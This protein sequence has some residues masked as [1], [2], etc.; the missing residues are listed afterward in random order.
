VNIFTAVDAAN[1]S[2]T[3]PSSAQVLLGWNTA[4]D[5]SGTAYAAGQATSIATNLT[6]YAQWSTRTI[7]LSETT[8]SGSGTELTITT[9]NG[10]TGMLPWSKQGSN[11][12]STGGGGVSTDNGVDFYT[13]TFNP[14]ANGRTYNIIQSGWRNDGAPEPKNHTAIF[15]RIV[16]SRNVNVTLNFDDIYMDGYV[17][18]ED[19][20]ELTLLL[21][22]TGSIGPVPAEK[23]WILQGI[24]GGAGSN[25]VVDSAAGTGLISG[26]IEIRGLNST[27]TAIDSAGRVAIIG[28]NT[29]LRGYDDPG[30]GVSAAVFDMSGGKLW[31]QG[32]TAGAG[33]G[34]FTFTGGTFDGKCIGAT[35]AGI[36]ADLLDVSAGTVRGVVEG[37]YG[38]YANDT[39]IS[40]GQVTAQVLYFSVPTAAGLGGTNIAIRGGDVTA[41]I[42]GEGSAISAEVLNISA[43]TV[44]ATAMSNHPADGGAGIGGGVGLAGGSVVISGGIVAAQGASGAAG[45]G[46]GAGGAGGSVTVTGGQVTA[47]G[48]DG[49]GA[50]IGGGAGGAGAV[51]AIDAAVDVLAYSWGDLPAIHSVNDNSD[52]GDG[53]YVN[54]VLTAAIPVATQ[55]DVTDPVNST[56]YR[57]L[58]LPRYYRA[59]AYSTGGSSQRNDEVWVCD[60]GGNLLG[61]IVRTAD[62]GVVYSMIDLG[63]YNPFNTVKNKGWLPVKFRHYFVVTE[64]HV[65]AAGIPLPA[66]VV[67]TVTQVPRATPVYSKG[68]PAL[69][70]YTPL[71]FY[72]GEVYPPATGSLDTGGTVRV[73][74]VIDHFTVYFVYAPGTDLTVTKIVTGANADK[75]RSFLFA[76]YFFDDAAGTDPLAATSF[77]FTKT[78]PGLDPPVE[79]ELEVEASNRVVFSLK[80]GESITIHGVPLA[81]YVQVSERPDD[82]YDT[83]FQDSVELDDESGGDTAAG[84]VGPRLMTVDRGFVFTNTRIEVPVTSVASNDTAYAGLIAV[85]ASLVALALVLPLGNW[86]RASQ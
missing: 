11:S 16:V 40:G 45:I 68:V 50:G 44:T 30:M 86:K 17:V 72:V 38:I 12:L 31:A 74:P 81:A 60:T 79:G 36:K 85:G 57:S 66:P 21:N 13:V 46:G 42:Q 48:G 9:S 6:L 59:F 18:V 1:K 58:M 19:G 4:A 32:F 28:G 62:D 77:E 80:D 73:D 56:V 75:T 5:G 51:V 29:I 8:S 33:G 47:T 43:G 70:G 23:S 35:C 54:A 84:G 20:A 22:N 3:P 64:K 2:I 39:D 7:D 49:G 76:G 25:V 34:T 10:G 41:K 52:D 63:D 27:N 53:H 26:A 82:R 24:S 78:G 69:A 55:L 14:A 83:R 15:S 37:K 67:D 71:G 65:D 61:D